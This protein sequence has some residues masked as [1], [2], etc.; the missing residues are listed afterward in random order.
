MS[1][2]NI[3]NKRN[4]SVNRAVAEYMVKQSM[5]VLKKLRF[6]VGNVEKCNHRLMLDLY[7]LTCSDWCNLDADEHAIIREKVILKTIR[8]FNVI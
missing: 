2:Q 1:T 3:L 8:S 7:R 6:G 5:E 4:L